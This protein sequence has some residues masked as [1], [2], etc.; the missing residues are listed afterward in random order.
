MYTKSMKHFFTA[1][2]LFCLGA[3][4]F[5]APSSQLEDFSVSPGRFLISRVAAGKPV[6]FCVYMPEKEWLFVTPED[7][8]LHVRAAFYEWT[9]GTAQ[10]IRAAGR[11]QEF[12]DVLPLLD[13]A[14]FE[15]L[16]SCNLSTDAKELFKNNSSGT[17]ADISVI[18]SPHY[19]AGRFHKSNAFFLDDLPEEAPFICF[20]DFYP[21]LLEPVDYSVTSMCREEQDKEIL[22]GARELLQTAAGGN[23]SAQARRDLWRLNRCYS[24]EKGALFAVL[25]HEL[26]HA[27]GAADE[28][29]AVN[30]DP[31]YSSVEP[32]EGVMQR[33]YDSFGCSETDTVIKL[34]D[35]SLG[36][37]RTFAS[38][39]QNGVSFENGVQT[40]LQTTPAKAVLQPGRTVLLSLTAQS[41]ASQTL[42]AEIWE[43]E[44]SEE[45]LAVLRALG[46][47]EEASGAEVYCGGAQ[48]NTGERTGEWE[49]FLARAESFLAARIIYDASGRLQ[50]AAVKKADQK[51]V[52]QRFERMKRV[53]EQK[54]SRLK[55]ELKKSL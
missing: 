37:R 52:R 6:T 3:G 26:G 48:K 55:N 27:F 18:A 23:L 29:T 30:A 44:F 31:L 43:K 54:I 47:E 49:C 8:S 40:V 38:F 42:L 10:S 45:T 51:Y 19:C 41:A 14:R 13:N 46:W 17:A 28:Y 16:P 20:G 9:Q 22:A 33:L 1:A 32:Q 53:P 7:F 35:Q 39:C 34:L 12:A 21:S 15:Q 50:Q 4:A 36:R 25:V 11:A 24:Y 2:A 5:A